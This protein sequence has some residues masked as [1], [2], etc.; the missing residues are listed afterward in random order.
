M[1]VNIQTQKTL[2][3]SKLKLDPMFAN[4]GFPSDPTVAGID[5]LIGDRYEGEGSEQVFV[6]AKYARV[7]MIAPPAVDQYEI[8]VSD[9]AELIGDEWVQKWEVRDMTSDEKKAAIINAITALEAE[10]TPRRLREAALGDADA[11]AYIQNI[12]DQIQQL[13]I[14]YAGA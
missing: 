14:E 8:A 5:E 1:F 12:D 6:P 11:I 9:S 3:Y 10:Q 2:S 13:R 4:V 7:V